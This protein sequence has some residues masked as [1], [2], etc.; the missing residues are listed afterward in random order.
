MVEPIGP[1]LVHMSPALVMG[2][3]LILNLVMRRSRERAREAADS[4][5]MALAL[6]VELQS[7]HDAYKE[8]LNLIA[9]GSHFLVST[10]AAGAVFRASINRSVQ[11][12]DDAGL[13]P[14]IA[15]F[16]YQQR[17]EAY[18]SACTKP[19]GAS[20]VLVLPKTPLQELKQRYVR[21]ARSVQAALAALEP[22]TALPGAEP[23][24]ARAQPVETAAPRAALLATR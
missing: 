24:A 2:A 17:I 1:L 18:L 10:R 9:A 14:V 8:N 13:A 20:A 23:A 4:R 19:N 7:L 3:V 16:S 21:G 22:L 6:S 15:A 5:H 11:V 12:L